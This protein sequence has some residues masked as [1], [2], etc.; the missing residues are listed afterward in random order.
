[1]VSD[2]SSA[3]FGLPWGQ[4]RSY[5]NVYGAGT[6]SSG[7]NGNGWTVEQIPSLYVN[8]QSKTAAAVIGGTV[9]WF[10]WLGEAYFQPMY[11]FTARLFLQSGQVGVVGAVYRLLT[12]DSG[13]VYTFNAVSA[14]QCQ[15]RSALN[16]MGDEMLAAYDGFGR[17]SSLS[18]SAPGVAGS[19]GQLHVQL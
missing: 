2:L 15:F 7:I 10:S 3:G 12:G 8:T 18:L 5:S 9:Y 16:A 11:G 19:G 14:T 1:M 6:M 13:V 4:T 17:L